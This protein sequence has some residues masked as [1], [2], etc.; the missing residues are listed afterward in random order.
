MGASPHDVLQ[1]VSLLAGGQVRT[2][3]AASAR[4]G[5]PVNVVNRGNAVVGGQRKVVTSTAM[6]FVWTKMLN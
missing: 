2:G 1:A 6:C 5:V 3:R 4:A